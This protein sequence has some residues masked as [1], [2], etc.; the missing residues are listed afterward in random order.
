MARERTHVGL[1]DGILGG[2]W[3]VGWEG[4]V[5]WGGGYI[6]GGVWC[7]GGGYGRFGWGFGFDLDSGAYL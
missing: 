2:G 5:Y 4:M 1:G 6:V 3:Y 7:I